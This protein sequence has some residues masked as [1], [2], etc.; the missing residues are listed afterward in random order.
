MGD[1]QLGRR[2]IQGGI[3][4]FLLFFAYSYGKRGLQDHPPLG[5]L[6]RTPKQSKGKIFQTPFL[7]VLKIPDP[8]HFEAAIGGKKITFFY[9]N[10]NLQLNDYVVALAKFEKPGYH[11]VIRLEVHPLRGYKRGFSL[12][13]LLLL[14]MYCLW[15]K[16]TY[17]AI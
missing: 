14:L 8:D 5:Y 13:G 10:H 4:F 7:R 15:W 12:L 6:E 2:A 9:P 3:V 11:Q 17:G 16:R 1:F